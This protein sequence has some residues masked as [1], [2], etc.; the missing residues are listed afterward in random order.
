MRRCKVPG[1]DRPW[2]QVSDKAF[3]CKYHW[4]KLPISLQEAV[5]Q[6][7]LLGFGSKEYGRAKQTAIRYWIDVGAGLVQRVDNR[8]EDAPSR[9][10]NWHRNRKRSRR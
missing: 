4:K 1:C 8:P 7:E 10:R 2:R 3:L 9:E 6:A 5:F